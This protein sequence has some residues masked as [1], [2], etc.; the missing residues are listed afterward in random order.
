MLVPRRESWDKYFMDIAR[1]VSSRATCDR[2]H[3]G[4]VLV[5]KKRI[6]A[7]GYNGSVS[8]AKECDTHGHLMQD[9]HCVRTIHAEINSVI[10]A[11]RNGV[12]VDGAV[13]YCT[14]QPCFSCTKVLLNAGVEAIYFLNSYR[15]D[16]NVKN[17][18]LELYGA[19]WESHYR[20]LSF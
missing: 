14:V 1:M 12:A 16:D 19:E 7:T 13:A 4:C 10:N 9:D 8:K 18:L 17:L 2:A 5:K 20:H 6:L 15:P 11:A 3:V